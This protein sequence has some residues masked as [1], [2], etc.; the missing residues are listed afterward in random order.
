MPSD[1]LYL[2]ILPVASGVC[3][4]A[5]GTPGRLVRPVWTL[6]PAL[7][8]RELASVYS[9]TSLTADWNQ[10]AKKAEARWIGMNA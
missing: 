10:V 3:G 8:S 1:R 7:L 6:V 5:Q 2:I 4:I 9:K